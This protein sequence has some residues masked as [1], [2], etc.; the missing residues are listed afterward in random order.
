LTVSSGHG[1]DG[2]VP[3]SQVAAMGRADDE[4]DEALR[5]LDIELGATIERLDRVRAEL[6][7][8]L[9]HRAPAHLPPGFAPASREL[10]EDAMAQALAELSDPAQL[11]VLVRLNALLTE[12]G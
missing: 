9:R 4:P 2:R 8:I 1:L 11:R 3:L 6:A 5:V 7:V 10:A 12:Q